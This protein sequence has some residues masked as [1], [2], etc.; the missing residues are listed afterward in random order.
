[1]KGIKSMKIE[2]EPG[3]L[4]KI[5]E[6]G[7]LHPSEIRC[8]DKETKL[9]LKTLCLKLCQPKNCKQCDL[10]SSCAINQ[11]FSEVKQIHQ[12]RLVSVESDRVMD[13]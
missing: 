11:T 1:M 7:L 13:C 9:L 2:I 10:Q 6:A 5:V 3:Q 12:H 4:A 8:L